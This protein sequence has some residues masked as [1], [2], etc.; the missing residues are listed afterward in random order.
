MVGFIIYYVLLA[1]VSYAILVIYGLL[2]ICCRAD[3]WNWV[4]SLHSFIMNS[5]FRIVVTIIYQLI[6]VVTI[7]FKYYCDSMHDSHNN[8]KIYINSKIHWLSDDGKELFIATCRRWP[9]VLIFVTGPAKIDHLSAKKP[10]IFSSWLYHNIVTICTTTTS[11]SVLQNL[12]G[13]LLQVMEMGYYILKV[14]Y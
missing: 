3:Y 5:W 1:I 11:S 13:F 2:H 7:N 8:I 6:A 10:L 12:M 4:L 9:Q 14:R